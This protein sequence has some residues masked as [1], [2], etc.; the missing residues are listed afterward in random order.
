[1]QNE[2]QMVAA[3]AGI[4]DERTR[5]MYEQ[6][7]GGATLAETGAQF[8]VTRERVRQIFRDAQ[9]PQRTIAETAAL[10]RYRDARIY[11]TAICRAFEDLRDIEEVATH[12]G[13]AKA[14]VKQVVDDNFTAREQRRTK[15]APK[16]YSNEELVVFLQQASKALGGVLTAHSY[17]DYAKRRRTRDG[18]RWPTHQTHFNRFGS[19]RAA[20]GTAGLAANPPSAIAG[21]RLFDEGHCLDAVRALGRQLGR[22]PKAEEYDAFAR[23]SGGALPSLATVR[24]RCGRW[25]E[26]LDRAGL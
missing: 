6:Y 4:R 14:V 10:Q 9:L 24:N 18:R 23:A 17:N 19:W 7:I 20:L 3:L 22:A 26:V 12:L 25:N 15:A 8:N 2:P 5:A 13:V 1:M 11:R 16:K 21:Q